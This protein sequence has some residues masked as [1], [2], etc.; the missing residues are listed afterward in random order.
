MGSLLFE[1]GGVFILF[2]RTVHMNS[3]RAFWP[4]EVMSRSIEKP[5]SDN[6]VMKCRNQQRSRWVLACHH[7]TVAVHPR[8]HLT[9]RQKSAEFKSSDEGSRVTDPD[10]S[11]HLFRQILPQNP[12]KMCKPSFTLRQY[13][14]SCS[15]IN[16]SMAY[17]LETLCEK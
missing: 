5:G 6:S 9:H 7:L 14:F 17:F 16:E 11:V 4:L 2:S 1:E 3:S 8:I 15:V 10:F 13:P 12:A